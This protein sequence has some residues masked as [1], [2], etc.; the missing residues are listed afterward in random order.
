MLSFDVLFKCRNHLLHASGTQN[1][2]VDFNWLSS[3]SI[4][5]DIR[6]LVILNKKSKYVKVRFNKLWI[7]LGKCLGLDLEKSFINLYAFF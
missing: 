3:N 6:L 1:I 2:P 7:G 5:M 4:P